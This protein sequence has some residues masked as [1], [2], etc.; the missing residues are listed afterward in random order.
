[1][2]TPGQFAIEV[3][4]LTGRYVATS[5]NDRRVGE[6]P[7]HPARLFSALVAAWAELEKPDA[8]ER[9]ALEWLEVQAAPAITTPE[10]VPRR[11]VS[12]FVPVN[13]ATIVG[14]ALQ[15]RRADEI[16]TLTDQIHEALV[17]SGGKVTPA[18]A[19]LQKQV[20]KKRDVG[21]TVRSP[22]KTPAKAALAAALAMLP[23]GRGK[24]ER[25]FPSM[26]PN[27]PRVTYSWDVVPPDATAKTLDSL[28][29]RVTRLGH[30]SSL[31][32]CRVAPDPPI[33]THVP[34]T[35]AGGSILRTVRRGQLAELE[36]Q[37][38]RHQGVRPRS[39]PFAGV[40]YHPV[41]VSPDEP[42][43]TP[44]TSGRWIVFEFTH[45]SRAFP[46][47]RCVELATAMRRAVL[48]HAEDPIPEG[49]SGHRDDGK[50]SVSPHIAVLP[51]PYVGYRHADG[52]L[53]GVALSVPDGMDRASRTALY[54][55]IGIW[56]RTV[57]DDTGHADAPLTVT[58]GSRGVVRMRRGVDV[59]ELRSLRAD[60][61]QRP[62]RRWSSA[63][64]VALPRHPGS[65]TKGTVPVRAKAWARAEVS[66][67]LACA[68]VGL[69]DPA[70]V[71]LSFDP[72]IPGARRATHF[73]AFRQPG[74]KGKPVRRQLVHV[75]LTFDD[76]VAGPLMLG[77][78]RFVG[79]GLMRPT[80]P[81][82][83]QQ[84]ADE[85][86]DE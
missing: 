54:R 85:P 40:R 32:S 23:E 24:Q 1:M 13:D 10:A 16:R 70:I 72:R 73:P 68:H 50:P 5:H 20:A 31:V 45:D 3:N 56:E 29:T 67:R 79:L 35:N 4:F 18:V 71:E 53:L 11:T 2:S 49:I 19:R 83:T 30:S 17:A 36:R 7:P 55:A 6:W 57:R 9:S 80:P 60:P 81:R 46:A 69:P 26:S 52:R 41:G 59:S 44:N 14:R 66:A 22:R 47:T 34:A 39:L 77:T 58:M 42:I 65:L 38:A 75:S 12:H 43:I 61:W 84:P 15:E 8:E 76:P 28:L 63:T 48:S 74:R 64:P 33:P 51:I 21:N 25:T 82:S 78:G 62:S 86:S 27:V 37:H